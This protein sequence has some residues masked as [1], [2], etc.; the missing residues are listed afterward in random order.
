MIASKE[1]F[2]AR[3]TTCFSCEHYNP[4]LKQ[5]KQCGCFLFLKAALSNFNCP[6]HKWPGESNEAETCTTSSKAD[7]TIS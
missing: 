7:N 4:T 3:M 6:L 1:L 2:K 5:C